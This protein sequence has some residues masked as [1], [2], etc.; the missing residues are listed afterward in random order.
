MKSADARRGRFVES[1][2]ADN[3]VDIDGEDRQL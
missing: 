1:E 2:Q 3:A